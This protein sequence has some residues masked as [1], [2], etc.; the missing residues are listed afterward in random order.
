MKSLV[1]RRDL[2]TSSSLCFS[3]RVARFFLTVEVDSSDV[4]E[5]QA[6]LHGVH[7]AADPGAAGTQILVHAVQSVGDG[8]NRVDHELDLP[9]LLV[10][11]VP[12][13]PLLACRD[14]RQTWPCL[15]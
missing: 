7:L 5:Q 14:S 1:T 4:V 9:L 6:S 11:R 15:S 12:A 2:A 3:S 10:G 8:V 13:D